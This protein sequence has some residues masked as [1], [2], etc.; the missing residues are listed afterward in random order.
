MELVQ[1][2]GWVISVGKKNKGITKNMFSTTF[3]LG[4]TS[5]RRGNKNENGIFCH[6]FLFGGGKIC[7]KNS[8]EF[9]HHIPLDWVVGLVSTRFYFLGQVLESLLALAK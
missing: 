6:I 2:W 8:F 1:S 4:K 5:H 9:Y 3:V 7:Q